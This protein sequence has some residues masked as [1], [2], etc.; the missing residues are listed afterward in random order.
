MKPI[1]RIACI[2]IALLCPLVAAPVSIGD[3][4]FEGNA[5]VSGAWTHNLGPEWTGTGGVSSGNA[6]E[7]YVAGFA[8]AGNDHLGMELNYDVWQN[9][10]V[11]YQSNTRYT[12]TVAAGH[13]GGTTQPGNQSQ[14]LLADSTGAIYSTGIFNASSL[15]AQTFGDAPALVFDTPDNP[16]AVGKTIRVLLQS[17]GSGRSHFDNIRLDATSLVPP[18]TATVVNQ[19]ASAVTTATATLNGQVSNIGNGAPSITLFWGTANG[20]PATAGW[21]HSLALAGTHTGSYSG[22]ISGLAPATSYYFTSRATNVAGESWAI[23]SG[24]FETPPLPPSVANVAATAIAPTTATVGANV[25]ATGGEIPTVTI[26]Y[27]LSDGGTTAASWASSV[28]LGPLSGSATTALGGLSSG[29]TYHFRAFAQNSGGQAWAAA[30]SN[31]ATPVV[32]LATVT[33]KAAEGITGTTASLRGEVTADG[34]DPPVVT[35]FYGT[36]NGGTNPAAWSSS[37]N[38]GVQSGDLSHFANALSPQTTYYFR[39]RAVNAAGTSWAASS[40]SFAT[41]PLVPNTAVINEIHYRPADKTSVEDFIELHNPGDAALDLSG[42]TLSGAVT[43]TFPGGTSLPAGGFL[44]VAEKPSVILSKYG[45]SALGPWTGKLNSTGER[46]ELK[47]SGGV[48]KDSVEYGVGFPWPTGPDGSGSSAELLHPGLDNDLG[49]SWRA[50]GSMAVPPVTYIASQATGWKYKKGS[51]E[52]SS[53]VDAWRAN[54]YND[55]S[56]FTGQT[57]IGYGDPGIMTTLSD[58]PGGYRSVY[59]RKSFT[60]AAGSIPS[61]LRLR[62]RVDDGCVV[63]INGTEVRRLNVANGQLAYTYL[64]PVA[65]ENAWEEYVIN[66]ADS[67]L[68]GGTNVISVHTFNNSDSSSDFSMDLELFSATNTSAVPTPGAVNSVKAATAVIPPQIRQ[69]VH[70]PVTPVAGQQVTITAKVTDPDGIGTVNLAYQTVDPG[71]YIRLTDP[72]YATSWTTVQMRDNGL[73]GDAA[74]GDS[75]YTV[76]LPANVQ[77]NRRLVRY[78]ITFSDDLGNTATIPY[79]DDQQPNFA[80]YVYGG[81]PTWQGAFRPGS[82]TLQ[83]FPST[84]LDDLPVYSLIANGSDVINSQYSSGSDAIRFRGTFVYDGV[85][86]DHIE[87]KNRGEASTYV[88]G[89]NKWRFFFNRSRDLPAMNNFGEDYSEKWGSFSGDACASP[90]AS[91]HRGMAGV[92]EASSYKVFQLGGLPSP[93][94]HYYHFRVVRGATETPAAGTIINDPIGNAEGQYAGDFWGL[95]LAVEQPDGSFLDERGLPDGSVYK[96]EGNGGDKKNQGVT[97]PVDSSDWNAFRDAHVNGDPTEA[98]WRANMDM[99]AYYSFHALNRLTGNVDLRGGY[100]HYFYHRSTDNRWVPMPWDLDMMFMAKTHWSTSVNGTDYPGVIHAY[101]SILQNPALALEYRNRA[102]ELLD[103]VAGDSTPG[104]GQF[105]QLIDEFASIVNPAG[106]TLTWADADAAM[107]NLHP[108]TQ[109]SDS[110]ASGQTNHKGNFYRTSYADSRIG[111]DWTR[112]LR[113]SGSSG[114]MAHEDSMIYLRDYGTNAWPGGSWSVS[115]GN[116]LGYGYQ[117][118]VADAADSAIPQRPVVTASGDPAFPTSD[119]KFTSSAFA[120]PQGAGTY[121]RTQWRLSEISGPGVSGYVAGAPRKYEIISIWTNESTVAPGSVSIPYGVAKP[122]K[123]YRVRV[124]HRDT[125][126]RW[127]RWSA[128]AQFAASTPPPGLLMHYWNFNAINPANLLKVTET[129]GGGTITPVLTGGAAVEDDNGEDFSAEN[130]RDGDLAG[131]HLR[132]NTPLGA[133]LTFALPTTDH[134]NVVVKY[135]TRRSGQG[136]GLQN[137]SYTTD[138]STWIPYTTVTVVDG[139]PVLQ[140]LDFRGN[141]AADDNPLFAVRITFQQ[142]AG[143]TGGNNRFDNFTIEG[144]ELDVEPGTYAYWRSEHFS[145]GDLTN[146]AVSGP[147]ATP[148]G[149]GI[150]NIMRYAHGVGPYEPVLHLLPVLVKDG[151]GHE[152]RFR[153]DPALTDLVWKVK[154][155]NDLGSWTSTLFDS[156]VGPVPPMEDGWLPV[157]LP[158]SLTGN[159]WPDPQIF[160]RLEVL[161]IP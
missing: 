34:G 59:F 89:K 18:G 39:S 79:S 101:K 100:N 152:F 66:N 6:F 140:L 5:N 125:S 155:S 38:L 31:F 117:Y 93:N 122:G 156:T 149:D 104:G 105:G 129:I 8:A 45:K 52:A 126:G 123:T 23:S 137:V 111:G 43:F 24:S 144:D 157:T 114:T 133:T 73:T 17:R 108:R 131:N 97:Q 113:S 25:T 116:Q 12:L 13:R 48:E 106:Q 75:I 148:A 3:P 132:V 159:P 127:S 109:G 85:V 76:R 30:S 153:F 99:E 64:S 145:G 35:L 128:P 22:V 146:E 90:W 2:A 29:S 96:I 121:S 56:W 32:A 1:L 54:G 102:R 86:Y 19:S 78:K 58:M 136:A 154:A 55:S 61:Q 138:G 130:A 83:S 74:S 57:G 82:T 9:L 161:A 120:D 68:F 49:G 88:S 151:G 112:W 40:A 42:W 62:L 84:L 10:A 95:Y 110:A 92:E 7:E 115:N 143:G 63:W 98:W 139:P 94:T 81:L 36:S 14:Y 27:G 28:S 87:F 15:P 41:T 67:F 53:P 70:S 26:Y 80:Y 50:S 135:E 91:L 47:D 103:L 150:S 107:W 11:T 37:V 51:E 147:E 44:V 160:V 124:R 21:Q 141:M 20:G 65:H 16:A 69:V 118:L 72:A 119:L 158:A 4:S 71:N 33:N 134:G 46:I 142:G 60:V 77:T